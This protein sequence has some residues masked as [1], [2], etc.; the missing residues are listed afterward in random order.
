M[1]VMEKE[2]KCAQDEIVDIEKKYTEEEIK[3]IIEE[4]LRKAGLKADEELKVDELE[5]VSGGGDP[6]VNFC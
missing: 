2:K 6:T 5:K 3:A 1:K 4:E